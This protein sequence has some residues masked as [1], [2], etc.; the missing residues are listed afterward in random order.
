M[1]DLGAPKTQIYGPAPAYNTNADSELRDAVNA[2]LIAEAGLVSQIDT[3]DKGQAKA[4]GQ[5]ENVFGAIHEEQKEGSPVKDSKENRV[6]ECKPQPYLIVRAVEGSDRPVE[7]A[8]AEGVTLCIIA[9][10]CQYVMSQP[11]GQ[12]NLAV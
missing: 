4:E 12:T 3:T 11:N 5:E 10:E 7:F 6:I 1:C 9:H 8:D 2:S